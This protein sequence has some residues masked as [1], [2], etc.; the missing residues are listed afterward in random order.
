M[1]ELNVGTD[2]LLRPHQVKNYEEDRAALRAKLRMTNPDG[3]RADG[4][5]IQDKGEA[6]KQ[7]RRLEKTMEPQLPKPFKGAELDAAVRLEKALREQWTEGM[8]SDEEMRKN[9]PHAVQKHMAW[10]KRNKRAVVE[11]KNLQL[12]L[13]VGSDDRSVTN[14][15]QHRPRASSLNMDGAQIQ[16]VQYYLPPPGAAPSAVFSEAQLAMLELLIPGARERIGTMDNKT[17]RAIKDA[18]QPPEKI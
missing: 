18:L 3:S 15:E 11:W 6:V 7:L 14:I 8:P 5:Y 17:R 4:H 12:R 2:P 10:E 13:N 16:G 9:P 1:A